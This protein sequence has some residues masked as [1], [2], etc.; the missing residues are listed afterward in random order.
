M[1]LFSGVFHL[2]NRLQSV[3][4]RSQH[5]RTKIV[6]DVCVITLDSPGVKVSKT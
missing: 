4:S 2:P 5:T 1:L 6:D 3:E